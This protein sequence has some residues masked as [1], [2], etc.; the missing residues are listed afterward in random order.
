MDIHQMNSTAE[1]AKVFKETPKTRNSG[2]D[3]ERQGLTPPMKPRVLFPE[4]H[5]FS[6]D[7]KLSK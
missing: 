6:L 3:G 2:G 1:K 4:G 5:E 7:N